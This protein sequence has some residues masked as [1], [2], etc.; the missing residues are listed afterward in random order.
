MRFLPRPMTQI[1]SFRWLAVSAAVL[2]FLPLLHAKETPPQVVLWPETGT[3]V[4]QFTFPKFRQMGW[5]GNQRVYAIDT[6]VKN[7]STKIIGQASFDLY[8]YDKNNV[9]IGDAWLTVSNAAPGDVIKFETN[10]TVSGQPVTVKLAPRAPKAISLT[11]NSVPQ[12]AHF[13][14]D[15]RDEGTTPK[16]IDVSVGSHLLEFDKEGFNHG[17]YPFTVGAN[18]VSGGNVSYDLGVAAHDTIELRDGS[19]L[20]GDLL[21][22]TATEVTV[23]IGGTAQTLNRNL[24]KRISL[25][26]RDQAG[27]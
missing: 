19:V 5:N 14:L 25:T 16:Q 23:Q 4:L 3:P 21:S 18:D 10:A 24:V 15:G 7:L 27:Q 8:L 1:R 9:R 17:K 12:G 2:L 26:Q 13:T 6:E 11:V 20:T 22:M